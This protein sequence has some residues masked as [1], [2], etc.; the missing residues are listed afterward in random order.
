MFEGLSFSLAQS[1]KPDSEILVETSDSDDIEIIVAFGS[2]SPIS[3][4]LKCLFPSESDETQ[5]A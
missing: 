4:L 3:V 1:N 2:D 5:N